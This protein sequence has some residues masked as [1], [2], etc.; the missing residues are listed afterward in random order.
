MAQNNKPWW[1][2]WENDPE[3]FVRRLGLTLTKRP[4]AEWQKMYEEMKK[5]IHERWDEIDIPD[6]GERVHSRLGCNG[7]EKCETKVD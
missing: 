4:E 6:L 2:G 7:I 1:D 3:V 5:E